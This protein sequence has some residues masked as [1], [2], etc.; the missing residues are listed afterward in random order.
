MLIRALVQLCPILSATTDAFAQFLEHVEP[1]RRI[2]FFCRFV[3]IGGVAKDEGS[4]V[5][6]SLQALFMTVLICPCDPEKLGFVAQIDRRIPGDSR[7][8][9]GIE[10]SFEKVAAT[11]TRSNER[12]RI[13]FQWS[14]AIDACFENRKQSRTV[15]SFCV[16]ACFQFGCLRRSTRREVGG[17]QILVCQRRRSTT[18]VGQESGRLFHNWIREIL[19]LSGIL[20]LRHNMLPRRIYASQTESPAGGSAGDSGRVA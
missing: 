18:F 15:E 13:R 8:A 9:T 19:G 14:N 1:K 6:V 3:G 10:L 5:A 12:C 2:V 20:C 7:K 16:N 11:E 4:D 17:Q